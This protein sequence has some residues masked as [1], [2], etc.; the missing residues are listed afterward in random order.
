M[1]GTQASDP[2]VQAE[3][4][5]SLASD[6]LSTAEEV[7]AIGAE[8]VIEKT[9]T[10]FPRIDGTPTEHPFQSRFNIRTGLVH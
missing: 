8:E 9:K 2:E 7:E 5:A 3:Y 1:L 10:V 4:N 6:A